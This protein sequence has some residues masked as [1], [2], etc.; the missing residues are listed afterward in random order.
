MVITLSSISLVG[1]RSSSSFTSVFSSIAF[2][3]LTGLSLCWALSSEEVLIE[4]SSVSSFL[5]FESLFRR[6]GPRANRRA[7]YSFSC[8][9]TPC[10]PT[11]IGVTENVICSRPSTP[12]SVPVIKMGQVFWDLSAL[13]VFPN[14]NIADLRSRRCDSVSPRAPGTQVGRQG[15]RLR[16]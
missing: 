9:C 10:S 12:A 2:S 11:S 16:D 4:F 7:G 14:N 1:C 3:S 15:A 6:S 13:F 8:P 5:P